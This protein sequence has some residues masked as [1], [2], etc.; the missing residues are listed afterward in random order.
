MGE[1]LTLQSCRSVAATAAIG[2]ASFILFILAQTNSTQS[3]LT[4][5]HS[6]STGST[7][8]GGERRF[9]HSRV[10]SFRFSCLAVMKCRL[11]FGSWACTEPLLSRGREATASV[12][13]RKFSRKI[14][15]DT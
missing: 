2:A 12:R 15:I 13:R 8:L 7:E 1:L 5:F 11:V 4:F 6:F 3:T 10:F 9:V 14:I